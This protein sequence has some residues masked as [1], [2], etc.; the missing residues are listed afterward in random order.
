MK[1]Q[2]SLKGNSIKILSE[3]SLLKES[4]LK[5]ALKDWRASVVELPSSENEEPI[6]ILIPSQNLKDYEVANLI[7]DINEVFED[8]GITIDQ[9]HD[10]TGTLD[11]FKQDEKNFL[12]DCEAARS[13]W[14]GNID[15]PQFKEFSRIV[16]EKIST[17]EFPDGLYAK[18]LLA[19]YHLAASGSACNFSVPGAGKT[20]N[21]WAAFAYLNSLPEDDPKHIN[22]IFVLGPNACFEPWEFEFSKCF[23]R[24]CKSVRFLPSISLEEKRRILKGITQADN[25]LY[26]CH[27]QTFSLYPKDF[28][29]LFKRPEKKIMLVVDEAH[30][31]KGQD[32]K[33]SN[34]ALAMAPFARSRIILTGTPAPNGYEDL[35][36]LFDFIHPNRNIIGFSRSA[37]KLMS[38][39]KLPTKE[40]AE[41]VKPF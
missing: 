7:K 32:G 1:A 35:K 41:R 30:N 28:L 13:V 15:V 2:L 9:A 29:E 20:L 33:W 8:L 34:A 36:N 22:S 12:R 39:N 16:K 6:E 24:K 27:F 19:S 38:E 25:E 11:G 3:A 31:I 10:V 26:L 37:L 4:E 17:K 40:L 14:E 5:L 23:D 18:Q 21:V